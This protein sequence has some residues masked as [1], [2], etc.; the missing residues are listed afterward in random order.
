MSGCDKFCTFCI[1][2]YSRG[3]ERSRNAGNVL[4]E[5]A[6]L[7]D[8]DYK[9]ITLVG[10]NVNSYRPDDDQ[11]F[12]SKNNPYK[13]HFAALLWEI[14]RIG[15]PWVHF[16]SPHPRDMTDE[17]IDALNLPCM[18][19]FLHLPVQSGDSQVLRRMNRGYTSEDFLHLVEKI[20]KKKP[21]TAIGT[22]IIVGFPGETDKE[23]QN[24]VKLYK[25]VDFDISYTA[26]Y[27]PR[28]NTPAARMKD[29]V[30]HDIKKE[31]W[32]ILQ[33]LMEEIVEKKNKKFKDQTVEVI[34]R[35][36]KK[37]MI[38]GETRELKKITLQDNLPIGSLQKVK[39]Q[40]TSTWMLYAKRNQTVKGKQPEA[41]K[42]ISQSVLSA[43]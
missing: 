1:V 28:Y 11:T 34:V 3:R 42:S 15:I 31:R 4:T 43:A 30:E 38:I 10:Q 21:D 6:K 17:V 26:I 14:N 37:N 8:Q 36:K 39:V 33:Q 19:N 20:K 40:E 16:T 32:N 24:T 13:D 23:F 9:F 2:P 18:I 5:I 7:R 22:D 41:F 25:E 35:E 27:S 29:Q 12:R